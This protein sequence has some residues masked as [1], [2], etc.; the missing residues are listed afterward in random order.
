MSNKKSNTPKSPKRPA[1]PRKSKTDAKAPGEDKVAK[2]SKQSERSALRELREQAAK[3]AKKE[4]EVILRRI[5]ENAPE[6]QR[7]FDAA[8]D[9]DLFI[10]WAIVKRGTMA[11]MGLKS[12]AEMLG[13]SSKQ[14]ST[15]IKME[16]G[17]SWRPF[18]QYYRA[19]GIDQILLKQYEVAVD[20]GNT[21]LLIW[22]GKQYAG[23]GEQGLS[24]KEQ[25]N[26]FK[27]FTYRP[28]EQSDL[29]KNDEDDE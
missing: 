17:M 11:G 29:D 28:V 23:Q 13:L 4:K 3:E 26:L 25:S 21:T 27:G 22:L 14:L 12:I 10:D 2:I 1:K 24:N 7:V 16:F 8:V 19:A 5:K 15:R 18:Q 20:D 9:P 6:P